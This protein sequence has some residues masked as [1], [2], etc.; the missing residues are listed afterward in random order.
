MPIHDWTRMTAGTF[1]AF[2]NVWMAHLQK[3]LNGG[4]LPHGY[5]A[6]GAQRPGEVGPDVLTRH[7]DTD[8]FVYGASVPYTRETSLYWV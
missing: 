2:H 3:A 6:L 7:A 1:H 4:V 5:Y 8:G